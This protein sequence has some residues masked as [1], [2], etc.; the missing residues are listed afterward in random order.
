VVQPPQEP[1]PGEGPVKGRLTLDAS[2]PLADVFGFFQL[3]MPQNAAPT[4]CDWMTE[5]LARGHDE[6][7]G[8]EWHG[9]HFEI[10]E[11]QDGRIARVRVRLVGADK[12]EGSP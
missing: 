8:L 9:A 1:P 12:K 7:D 11:M 10:G 2:L 5:T 4:L 6:G 3:P